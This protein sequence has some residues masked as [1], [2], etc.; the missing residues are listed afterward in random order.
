MSDPQFDWRIEEEKVRDRAPGALSPTDR[1][2]QVSSSGHAV[3][4]TALIAVPLLAL[5]IVAVYLGVVRR[6]EVAMEDVKK[7]VLAVHALTQR[8]VEQLDADLL[9]TVL[10]E[11]DPAWKNTVLMLLGR[12]LLF[13]RATFN[14][15]ALPA[16]PKADKVTLSPDL[17]AAQVAA[18]RAY[19]TSAAHGL[20]QTIR[21]QHTVVYHF[22][23]QRWRFA[24]PDDEFWGRPITTTGAILTLAYPERDKALGQ[25]LARDL[26]AVLSQTCLELYSDACAGD[27]RMRL[28]LSGNPLSLIQMSEPDGIFTTVRSGVI[29]FA[30]PAPSLFGVPLDEPSY[31]ALYRT[32]AA[33]L[34]DVFADDVLG[35]RRRDSLAW[36]RQGLRD[37]LMVRLGLQPWPGIAVSEP[38][39]SPPGPRPEQDI[40][41]YCVD[42]LQRYGSL[43]RY[44][45]STDAWSTVSSGRLLAAMA[46]LPGG[47]GL[48]LQESMTADGAA[49]R[50]ILWQDGREKILLDALSTLDLVFPNVQIVPPGHKLIVRWQSVDIAG[51]RA[52]YLLIDLKRC[53][54]R[55]CETSTLSDLPVWSPD[56]SHTLVLSSRDSRLLLGNEDGQALIDLGGGIDPFWI[57]D[58]T[59]GYFTDPFGRAP[60]VVTATVANSETHPLLSLAG[61]VPEE[62]EQLGLWQI[63]PGQAAG[64]NMVIAVYTL[65]P[66]EARRTYWFLIDGRSGDT[67]P[68]P[69]ED[70]FFGLGLSP[71]ERWLV[72]FTFDAAARVLSLQF[73]DLHDFQ[74]SQLK[75]PAPESAY[76][77]LALAYAGENWSSDGQWFLSLND[78]TLYLIAPGYDYY[79]AIAPESPGC[80]FAAWINR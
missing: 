11:D 57:S 33:R 77:A 56:G 72:G 51:E 47:E 60:A 21:L 2:A 6:A 27:R 71:D 18:E 58:D 8:A 32:Y 48:L 22:D 15:S 3:R 35:L 29:D 52:D 40:A 44:S 73:F 65:P 55:G 12:G 31:Q 49:S 26:D 43:Y 45:S 75:T 30:L 4:R 68:L 42:G 46:P 16:G 34:V 7:D 67:K 59:Y 78:D 28:T 70:E 5:A 37:N 20:T 9:V 36:F 62:A 17:T 53:G 80:I 69:L 25:S 63:I 39:V 54:S 14:L 74:A 24:E 1:S 79:R 61:L 38:A 64:S 23:G 76:G 10:P 19:A 66:Q 13:D 50:L 41:V